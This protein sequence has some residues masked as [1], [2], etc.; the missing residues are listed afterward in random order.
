MSPPC[1]DSGASLGIKNQA[2]QGPQNQESRIL[3]G[4]ESRIKDCERVGIK[5]NVR[6][7][8]HMSVT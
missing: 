1:G 4:P 8:S 7:I 6:Y 2:T 5:N 3:R